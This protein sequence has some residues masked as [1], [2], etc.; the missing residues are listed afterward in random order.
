YD[1]STLKVKVIQALSEAPT[2]QEI[3]IEKLQGKYYGNYAG[4]QVGMYNYYIAFSDLGMNMDPTAT[5]NFTT[6]NAYYYLV[7]LYLDTPPTDLN[8]IVVPN[9]VYEYDI[10]NSGF[11]NTF[12]ESCSWYR[13]V[14]ES[15]FAMPEYEVHYD[16]GTLTVED[17]KVTLEVT[18]EIDH[19][20]QNHKVIYEGNYSLLDCTNEVY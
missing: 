19:T 5:D 3:K 18:F 16:K 15:G 6:P 11:M 1:K 9:G 7:D 4:L 8:N 13:R 14:D 20:Q 2:N 10:T 17:G 12:T